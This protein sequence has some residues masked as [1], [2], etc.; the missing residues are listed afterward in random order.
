MGTLG[1]ITGLTGGANVDIDL[2]GIAFALVVSSLVGILVS[3]LYQ[4]FYESRATGAQVHR[5]FLLMA[6]A[7]TALFIAIQFSL[8]LSLGLLGALS[9][10]RF[11]TPVKEPEEIAFIILLISGAV[12]C[13]TMQFALLGI[14]LGLALL[15][16]LLQ[17]AAPRLG[18]SNRK[19][20]MILVTLRRATD[21][22][23]RRRVAETIGGHVKRG[24]LESLSADDEATTLGFS[25]TGFEIDRL[26]PL[27][28]ALREVAPVER[29]NI[30]FNKQGALF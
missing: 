8:P 22:E 20:G 14:L 16:L 5:S 7:I 27:E 28:V 12:V 19:D 21:G 18:A 9:V 6:P 4:V 3:T 26:G 23:D 29:I 25:F 17:K 24:K 1:K 2:W 13:A 10:I 11:R 15:L 30:F